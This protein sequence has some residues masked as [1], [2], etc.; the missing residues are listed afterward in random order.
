MN[1]E[2]NSNYFEEKLFEINSARDGGNSAEEI[3]VLFQIARDARLAQAD[4]DRE[5]VE[6]CRCVNKGTWDSDGRKTL[7][8][9][10]LSTDI[11]S[12]L[13]EAGPK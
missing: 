4:A 7:G 6:K 9:F 1:M 11:L 5:A 3:R 2:L 8:V 13:A 10:V 12:A